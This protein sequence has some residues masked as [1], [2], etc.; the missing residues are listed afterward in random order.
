MPVPHIWT[1][2]G[3]MKIRARHDL[4]YDRPHSVPIFSS[5]S[6][7]GNM[8]SEHTNRGD[9]DVDSETVDR[10]TKYG[11]TRIQIS[12]FLY[13]DYRY[14]SLA[15]AIAEAERHARVGEACGVKSGSQLT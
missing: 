8:M 13:G 5:H 10:M 15:D 9:A 12:L 7:K 4:R 14:T 1:N 3:A 2:G 6:E 11:I